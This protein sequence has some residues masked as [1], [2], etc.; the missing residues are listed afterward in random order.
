MHALKPISLQPV[1]QLVLKLVN[2]EKFDMVYNKYSLSIYD[3][4]LLFKYV[5]KKN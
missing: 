3:I 5:L 4:L 1:L 2:D